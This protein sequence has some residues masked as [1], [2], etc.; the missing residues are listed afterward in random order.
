MGV[1]NDE[2]HATTPN[3]SSVPRIKYKNFYIF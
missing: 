1:L 3:R 2:Q